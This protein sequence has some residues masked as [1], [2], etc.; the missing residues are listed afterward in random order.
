MAKQIVTSHYLN[1]VCKP[2]QQLNAVFRFIGAYLESADDGL[3][4][5]C[6]PNS[7]N[8]AQ[9]G[10]VVAGGILATL[11]DEAMAHAIMSKTM[12][13]AVTIEMSN[14]F[15]NSCDPTIKGE[16]VATAK[17]IKAGHRIATAEAQVE[18]PDGT[19]L[20]VAS[21]SFY[22]MNNQPCSD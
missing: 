14:R 7:I 3:A 22:I 15:L 18:G 9:G 5:V 19:L 13:Q 16:I 4:R 20:S 8:L 12:R 17:V 10:G 2:E 21:G 6:I 11:A 1:E